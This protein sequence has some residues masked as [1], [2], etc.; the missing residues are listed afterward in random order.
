[1]SKAVLIAES[2]EMLSRALSDTLSFMGF[3]II[4]KTPLRSRVVALAEKT[5]PDLLLFDLALSGEGMAGLS[6]IQRLKQQLPELK[7]LLLGF[8]ESTDQIETK[9][10]DAGFN[11]LWNKCE[12]RACLIE[13]LKLLFP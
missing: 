8:H 5:K 4:G 11:G 2:N 3:S 7:I 9:I 10:A 13:K 6:D 1:M 12:G